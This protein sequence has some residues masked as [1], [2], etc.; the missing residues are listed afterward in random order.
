MAFHPD[1][2]SNSPM[3]V[4][5]VLVGAR[6]SL[7]VNQRIVTTGIDKQPVDAA[8]IRPLGLTGDAVCNKKH[9][10]GPDQAVYVYGT[11]DYDWWATDLGQLDPGT[12]GE[13]L[14]IDAF[15]CTERVIGDRLVI[16]DRVVLEVTAPRIPCTTLAARLA[17]P[18]FSVAFRRARRPGCYCRVIQ[19]GVVRPN[20]AVEIQPYEGEPLTLLDVFDAAYVANPTVADLERFLR[21]P[22]AARERDHKERLLERARGAC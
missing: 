7:E 13:N 21:A 14:L 17:R 19:P 11:I 10:G 20:D 5:H 12:F 22:I 16:G 15:T 18:D 8:E 6:A 9:H 4:S 3:H 2:V 1:A